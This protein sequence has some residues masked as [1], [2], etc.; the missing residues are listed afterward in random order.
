MSTVVITFP[1]RSEFRILDQ[2][3]G[4]W[5][6]QSRR[7]ERSVGART[8]EFSFRWLGER[9]TILIDVLV[10]GLTCQRAG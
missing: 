6:S 8:G 9:F 2:L 4:S 5:P 3:P 10:V 1:S 7:C